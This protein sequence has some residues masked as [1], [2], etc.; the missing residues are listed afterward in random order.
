MSNIFQMECLNVKMLCFGVILCLTIIF[1]QF[2]GA[3]ADDCYGMSGLLISRI[4]NLEKRMDIDF[5]IM[6]SEL[7]REVNGKKRRTSK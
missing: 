5:K 2:N 4:R 7:K 6:K 3:S 1:G